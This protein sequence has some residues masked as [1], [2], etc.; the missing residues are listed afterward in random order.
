MSQGEA[1]RTSASR[2]RRRG[3]RRSD[4]DAKPELDPRLRELA[5]L[6]RQLLDGSNGEVSQ[7]RV[8]EELK[9]AHYPLAPSTLSNILSGKRLPTLQ[10]VQQLAQLRGADQGFWQTEWAVVC[11][12]LRRDGLTHLFAVKLTDEERAALKDPAVRQRVAE[13]DEAA[14]AERERIRR[15]A[16]AVLDELESQRP[17]GR[18]KKGWSAED[19]WRD[20]TDFLVRL[21]TL[22]DE[23]P[24]TGYPAA[25]MPREEILR[26]LVLPRVAE[27]A[28]LT[29]QSEW[30]PL[31]EEI[32]AKYRMDIKDLTNGI[33]V[34]PYPD[35]SLPVHGDNYA[36]YRAKA[37]R[38][39]LILARKA[40][41]HVRPDV[42][43]PPA[44]P[45]P[46]YPPAPDDYAQDFFDRPLRQR[47]AVMLGMLA[48]FSVPAVVMAAG[49]ASSSV[50]TLLMP[51]F[52]F[53]S[54]MFF[55][56]CYVAPVGGRHR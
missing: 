13:I 54:V 40:I 35:V 42:E 26:D 53:L 52:S 50:S 18:E 41:E 21:V 37:A 44:M 16:H 4:L 19:C 20:L 39:A 49:W 56:I 23:R 25:G 38:H 3:R 32:A 1:G 29:G 27:L 8:V 11:L 51:V 2:G 24:V 6:L 12:Q 48:I 46:G 17:S 31:A 9:A 47:A 5:R 43:L 34:M 28:G 15:A 55:A 30:R 14:A 36:R 22:F 10:I 33:A 7:I 45:S